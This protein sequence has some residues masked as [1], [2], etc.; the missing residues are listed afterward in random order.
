MLLSFSALCF[1]LLQIDTET[2][3]HFV[4]VSSRN[5]CTNIF[6]I[7]TYK[8]INLKPPQFILHLYGLF[9]TLFTRYIVTY[10]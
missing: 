6:N 10:F 7:N 9:I 4:S 3:R 8:Y 2:A 1:N 5:G